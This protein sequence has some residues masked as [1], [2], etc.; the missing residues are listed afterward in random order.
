MAVNGFKDFKLSWYH[1]LKVKF[2]EMC[3]IIWNCYINNFKL[4]SWLP[5]FDISCQG[6]GGDNANVNMWF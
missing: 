4:I 5:Q 3:C 1:F 6:H 2:C